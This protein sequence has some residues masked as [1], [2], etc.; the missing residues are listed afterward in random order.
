MTK[1][2]AAILA[3]SQQGQ[4]CL[5]KR[6]LEPSLIR[7]SR[8][9]CVINYYC[10]FKHSFHYSRATSKLCVLCKKKSYV[11]IVKVVMLH[12]GMPVFILES[13]RTLNA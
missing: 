4:L 1:A 10:D 9:R 5:E 8:A 2:M 12:S 13:Y 11:V 7:S 6:N 3:F